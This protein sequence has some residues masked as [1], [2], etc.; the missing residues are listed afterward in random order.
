MNQL[1]LQDLHK[2]VKRVS[3]NR[4]FSILNFSILNTLWSQS[5]RY[6]EVL[7]Y[8][9][10]I[11]PQCMRRGVIVVSCLS[12]LC[13]CVTHNLGDRIVITLETSINTE[14]IMLYSV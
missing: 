12:E 9:D 4:T 11:N 10:V 14:Q 7:L 2:D 6:T 5:G 8:L 13:V 1:H 3:F